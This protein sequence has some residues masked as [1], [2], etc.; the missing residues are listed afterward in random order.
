MG[1]LRM[2]LRYDTRDSQESPYEGW[3]AGGLVAWAPLQSGG[4]MGA[5][6]TLS[7]SQVFRTIPIFHRGGDSREE[8]PPTDTLA[9]GFTNEYTSGELPFFELPTLGGTER[10]RGY[11]AGRFRGRASW[12]GALEYR[13]W[14]LPRGAALTQS[15]RFER[16][17][18]ALFYEV[19]AVSDRA[20]TLFQEKVRHSYGTSLRVS[21]DR[22]NLLRFDFGFSE[23]GMEFSLGYGLSF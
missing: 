22:T 18:A 11:I 12:L 2:G 1:W 20:S 4:D 8:N 17:G 10:H 7:T 9:V 14:L 5:R 19:G 15:I 3:H 13:F 23:E 16:L 6:Y 21:I